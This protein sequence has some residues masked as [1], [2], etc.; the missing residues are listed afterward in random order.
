MYDHSKMLFPNATH[1]IGAQQASQVD[2]YKLFEQL[3]H[4]RRGYFYLHTKWPSLF[5]QN[6]NLPSG[7]DYYVVSS[8]MEHIDFEWLKSQTVGPIFYLTDFNFY[9]D[10]G[11]SDV[12]FLRW[13]DWHRAMDKMI[14]W[15]GKDYKKD[16]QYKAS[17]FCNRLTQ[18]KI[19][20]T[21]A[22]LE[23]I[24]E[25]QL[26]ISLSDWIQHNK[27]VHHWQATGNPVVDHLTEIFKSKYL[28]SKIRMDSWTN[29]LNHQFYTANP[30]QI[31]YQQAALHFTNESFHYSFMGDRVIPGPHLTEK[32]FKC[33]VGATAFIP[34]GQ[35][36]VYRTL[37]EFGMIF[38]YG[39]DLSFDSDSGNLTRME[40]IVDLIKK[41]QDLDA[42]DL[43]ANTKHSSLHNQD[44]VLSGDFARKCQKINENSLDIISKIIAN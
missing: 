21:T 2:G 7:Y 11:L 8:H 3:P 20:I 23:Y 25:Q 41:L 1:A 24:K 9:Q 4:D 34:V 6:Q 14:Q 30:G 44:C 26:L 10:Y 12:T 36:D 42:H 31:A 17:V 13:M 22:L 28:G 32:T 38:D 43:Y 18:S 16:I 39:L 5:E 37:E 15:F 33:L 35:F 40:K 29:S 19:V 27:D